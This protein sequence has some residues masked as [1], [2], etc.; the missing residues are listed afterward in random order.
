MP[1]KAAGSEELHRLHMKTV[2]R[3]KRSDRGHN[4]CQCQQ[5]QTDA[6]K[7]AWACVTDE[8]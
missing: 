6:I 8:G 7:M 1:T 5:D 3:T 2:T 4:R